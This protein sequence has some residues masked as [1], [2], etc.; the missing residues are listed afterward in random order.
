[1]TTHR[2]SSSLVVSPKQL[3]L[4]RWAEDTQPSG[5]SRQPL[6]LLHYFLETTSFFP[7]LKSLLLTDLEP[8]TRNSGLWYPLPYNTTREGKELP[9]PLLPTSPYRN[10]D[11]RAHRQTSSTKALLRKVP[12]V[13]DHQGLQVE[14]V[15]EQALEAVDGW[16]ESQ[17]HPTQPL[18]ATQQQEDRKRAVQPRSSGES[19]SPITTVTVQHLEDLPHINKKRIN[20]HCSNQKA[21]RIPLGGGQH[22]SVLSYK[23]PFLSTFEVQ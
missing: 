12:A 17:G 4:Q 9:A 14:T 20:E 21:M 16:N 23:L 11:C 1:M 3:S 7:H 8:W 19:V 10:T 6:S 22:K 18:K 2:L 13:Q 15:W 5:S